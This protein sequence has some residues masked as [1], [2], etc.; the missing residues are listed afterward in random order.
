MGKDTTFL[1]Q[2][3]GKKNIFCF[4]SWAKH[5]YFCFKSGAKTLEMGD[6][7]FTFYYIVV[8][9][10]VA[11]PKMWSALCQLMTTNHPDNRK[12]PSGRQQPIYKCVT[13]KT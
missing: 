7:L 12:Q 6:G 1:F 13:A 9:R 8:V 11:L 5:L 3:R 2:I 10:N 4:K